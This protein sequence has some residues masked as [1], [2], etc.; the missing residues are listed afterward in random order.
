MLHKNKDGIALIVS[1]IIAFIILALGSLALYL[2]T[3]STKIS[4]AFKRYNS[5]LA[6]AVGAFKDAE[7]VMGYIKSGVN[8]PVTPSTFVDEKRSC[9][10]YKLNNPTSRWTDSDLQNNGCLAH[11][12]NLASSTNIGDIVNYYDFKCSLGNYNVYIKVTNTSEGNT[13]FSVPKKLTSGGTTSSKYGTHVMHPPRIPYL[14]RIEIVS[15]SRI[16]SNDKTVISLLYG[17]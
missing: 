14:Y 9:L 15:E 6:A 16:S 1:L 10:F 7:T 5:S 13:A 12:V 2:S 4:G 17:Y 11:T 8:A 3:E